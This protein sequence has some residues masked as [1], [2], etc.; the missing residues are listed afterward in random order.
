MKLSA[1]EL[2]EKLCKYCPLEDEHK[3]IRSTPGGMTAGCEGSHCKEA[4]ENYIEENL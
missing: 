3:G 2:G 1:D 4:Y